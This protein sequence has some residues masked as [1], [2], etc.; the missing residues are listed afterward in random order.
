MS[1]QKIELGAVARIYHGPR[2]SWVHACKM[3]LRVQNQVHEP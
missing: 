2:L 1:I 3:T